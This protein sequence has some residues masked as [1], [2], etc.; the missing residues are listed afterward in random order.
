MHDKHYESRKAKTT[1]IWERREY[2]NTWCH[3]HTLFCGAMIVGKIIGRKCNCIIEMLKRSRNIN[4]MICM[5]QVARLVIVLG[6]WHFHQ[7]VLNLDEW[8]MWQ[9]AQ[10]QGSFADY[11]FS[12]F[13]VVFWLCYNFLSIFMSLNLDISCIGENS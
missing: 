1:Y 11:S 8:C 7:L 3:S 4:G 6:Y 12:V 5:L 10:W 2:I 13:Y 9:N